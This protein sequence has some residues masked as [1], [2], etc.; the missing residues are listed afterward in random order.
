MFG[1]SVG[2]LIQITELS[3]LA[4]YKYSLSLS[5]SLYIYIYKSSFKVLKY[6]VLIVEVLLYRVN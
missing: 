2:T 4:V 5:L 6:R 3:P 1:P